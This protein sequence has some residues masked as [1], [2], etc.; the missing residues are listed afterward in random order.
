MYIHVICMIKDFHLFLTQACG[1]RLLTKEKPA[2][3]PTE[4]LRLTFVTLSL[5]FYI[6]TSDL[7]TRNKN[8]GYL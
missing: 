6:F 8:S 4:E 1:F 7:T 3:F 2:W 5:P